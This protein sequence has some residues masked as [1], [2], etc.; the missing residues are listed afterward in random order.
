MD[1]SKPQR[2]TETWWKLRVLNRL[3]ANYSIGRKLVPCETR[4]ENNE[5]E[6]DISEE[7][8]YCE[9]FGCDNDNDVNDDYSDN[10][11]NGDDVDLDNDD[12]DG[13][14]GIVPKGDET[15]IKSGDPQTTM[16][17]PRY[18]DERAWSGISV[19]TIELISSLH[20]PKDPEPIICQIPFVLGDKTTKKINIDKSDFLHC[21]NNR[22]ENELVYQCLLFVTRKSDFR[23]T[24]EYVDTH[25]MQVN[26]A[27]EY[28]QSE[29]IPI[30][31]DVPSDS[32]SSEANYM[33]MME[34]PFVGS[35]AIVTNWIM[36]EFG[37]CDENPPPSST[38]KRPFFHSIVLLKH[39]I[40]SPKNLSV[41]MYC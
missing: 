3:I 26:Y 20:Y 38:D 28:K 23:W 2:G 41:V 29:L 4:I 7:I 21:Y 18:R 1:D 30:R 12:K 32:E 25:R 33:V 17:G 16:R 10:D 19:S 13:D 37:G 5:C 14:D 27:L 15:H 39:K 36:M 6:C 35:R 8:N 34:L 22:G 9:I 31:K 11:D 24:I 40:E